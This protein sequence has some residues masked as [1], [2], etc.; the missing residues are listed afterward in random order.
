MVVNVSIIDSTAAHT[1]ELSKTLRVA[2]RLE[3]SRLG[4]DPDKI[5]FKA[6]RISLYRKTVLIDG[7]VAAMWGVYGMPLGQQGFVW[8]LTGSGIEKISP[9]RF[10]SIYRKEVQI[11]KR[12]F[13]VLENF[14]DASYTEA[15][16]LLQLSG[17]HLEEP[18]IINNFPFHR[19]SCQ[20][21]M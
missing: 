13:P 2:D 19:F 6:Y 7:N 17:F 21:D 1:R 8:F 11:M 14:V 18:T 4:E 5:V 9:H 15:V 10:V 16:R 20:G 12:L 3:V